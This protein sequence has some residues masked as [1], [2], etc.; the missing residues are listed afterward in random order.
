LP[1]S[2]GDQNKFG[3]RGFTHVEGIKKAITVMQKK[4]LF[5]A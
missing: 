5:D 3:E 2:G 4:M 1:G